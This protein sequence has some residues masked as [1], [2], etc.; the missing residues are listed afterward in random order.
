MGDKEAAVIGNA[1]VQKAL[2]AQEERQ[3]IGVYVRGKREELNISLKCMAERLC[4]SV[5]DLQRMENGL[6]FGLNGYSK[7]LQ[8]EA[9]L[10]LQRV[11]ARRVGECQLAA[12][13]NS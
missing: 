13:K 11:D 10:L 6:A 7:K 1:L 12:I 3:D 8:F 9:V 5:K 4:C 2:K